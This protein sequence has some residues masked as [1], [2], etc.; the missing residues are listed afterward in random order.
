V[1]VFGV[2]FVRNEKVFAVKFQAPTPVCRRYGNFCY[3]IA[4]RMVS[5]PGLYSLI[6][7]LFVGGLGVIYAKPRA[8]LPARRSGAGQAAG[9]GSKR[10]S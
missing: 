6:A 9:G 1:P 3:W 2:L 7:L 4:V 8:A 10:A 5:R